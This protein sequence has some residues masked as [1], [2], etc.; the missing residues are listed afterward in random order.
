MSETAGAVVV[1]AGQ[2]IREQEVSGD[3]PRLAE[4]VHS[5]YPKVLAGRGDGRRAVRKAEEDCL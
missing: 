5:S 4:N 1:V 3:V 2:T